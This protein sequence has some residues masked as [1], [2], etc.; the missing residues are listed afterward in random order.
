MRMQEGGVCRRDREGD[1]G[2]EVSKSMIDRVED[3][4]ATALYKDPDAYRGYYGNAARAAIEAMREPTGEM[5]DVGADTLKFNPLT[6]TSEVD[7]NGFPSKTWQ[8]MID[9]ALSEGT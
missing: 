2:G 4:I 6:V 9:D 3:A 7:L 1:E 8:T 5:K